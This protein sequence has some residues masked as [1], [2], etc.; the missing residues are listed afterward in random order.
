MANLVGSLSLAELSDRLN[1]AVKDSSLLSAESYMYLQDSYSRIWYKYPWAFTHEITTIT[2]SAG[3]N[4]YIVPSQIAEVAAI[5]NYSQRTMIDMR[6]D[7]YMYFNSYSDDQ[8]TGPLYTMVNLYEDGPNTHLMFQETPSTSSMGDGDVIQ[9]FYCKHI[10]HNTS[11]GATATGNMTASNDYPSFSPQ[12][13]ALIVKEALLEA[14]KNK[15]DF[16][17][18]Y[19][20]AKQERDEMLFDM[21]RHYLTPKRSGVLKIYR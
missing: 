12:F 7:I 5:F 17:E 2:A 8:H 9:I 19:Q 21:R 1:M 16:Q 15:R 4:D 18:M 11:G 20:L 3:V 13:Q 14:I 10:I 6:K